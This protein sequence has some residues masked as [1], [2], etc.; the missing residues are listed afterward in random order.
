[1]VK[2]LRFKQE[3]VELAESTSA[4]NGPEFIS[5]SSTGKN[6]FEAINNARDAINSATHTNGAYWDDML[7]D[8][9]LDYDVYPIVVS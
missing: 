6:S 5:H 4:G 9:V 8:F 7:G 3:H 2:N 1:V